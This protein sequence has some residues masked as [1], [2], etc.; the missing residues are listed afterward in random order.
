M[1][2][3]AQGHFRVM[4]D[5]TTD[6]V[7]RRPVIALPPGPWLPKQKCSQKHVAQEQ[8][9][10]NYETEHCYVLH[11]HKNATKT[12]WDNSALFLGSRGE[13]GSREGPG[14]VP[15]REA[16]TERDGAQSQQRGGGTAGPKDR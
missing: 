15:L 2:Y 14:S 11:D 16:K 10:R 5:H 9:K 6:P 7:I 1:K 13:G 8:G 12:Y 3:S 4:E